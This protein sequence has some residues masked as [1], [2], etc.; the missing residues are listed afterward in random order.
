MMDA[1]VQQQ[2]QQIAVVCLPV[3]RTKTKLHD[4]GTRR[5]SL[6]VN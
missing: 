4:N 3:S 1:K 6:F 2:Q 5:H